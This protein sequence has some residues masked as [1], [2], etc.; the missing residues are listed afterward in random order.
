MAIKISDMNP[1][2]TPALSDEY[3]INQGGVTFRE[4]NQQALDLFNA[5]ALLESTAQVTG[6]DAALAAKLALAGGTMTGDLFLNGD[7][8]VGSQAVNKAYADA[9]G[10]GLTI[11]LECY[12]STTA[13]LAGYTYANGAAGVGATLTAGG[14]GAFT[15]DGTSPSINARIFAPFQSSMFQNGIYALT[16]VGDGSNP[17]VLTRATDYDQTSEI[18]P[19]NLVPVKNGTLY[20]NT[21]WLETAT[22]TTIGTDPINYI[23]F[24]G[25]PDSFL[26]VL[27]NLSDVNNAATSLTNIGGVPTSRTVSAGGLLTGGGDLSANRTITLSTSAVLQPSENLADLDDASDAR[28]NLGLGTA[29]VKDA[30][31][32]A[33]G[34]VVSYDGAP[35]S[36]GVGNLAIYS[37]SN[38]S[39]QDS[40][41]TPHGVASSAYNW[42]QGSNFD[43]NPWLLGTTFTSIANGQYL[44]DR[45]FYTAAAATGLLDCTKT[46]DAPTYAE[47]GIA[48]QN[49][50]RF[51]VS[52]ADASIG[53]TQRYGFCYRML[54]YDWQNLSQNTGRLTFWARSAVTGTY[55]IAFQN[56]GTNR[57]LIQ[58][59]TIN[60]ANTWELKEITLA[61]SP[62][63]GSWNYAN[64]VGLSIIWNL[65][66]GSNFFG[67]DGAWL[68]GANYATSA[69]ANFMAT[70]GNIYG[71]QLVQL[72]IGTE[73]YPFI[74]RPRAT[75]FLLCG[76][77]Q[78]S[79][80]PDGIPP[81]SATGTDG[82]FFVRNQTNTSGFG[83]QLD[84]TQ[85]MINAPTITTYNP[86]AAANSNWRD[87]TNN[88]NRTVAVDVI[89]ARGVALAG[90]AGGSGGNSSSNYI[91]VL[92]E[93]NL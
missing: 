5:E 17:A 36:S 72:T 4:S 24:S 52:T 31:D 88:A 10:A 53:A 20:K 80:F 38:G 34:V 51:T 41:F 1:V 49:S 6:L 14:N 79:T 58:T 48:S 2:V 65:A 67:T 71:I 69:Q 46:A 91:H 61:P 29:A 8:T 64:G 30:S 26:K 22:V 23:Q 15:T 66:T 90:A 7:P 70:V 83:D 39:I 60:L 44:A 78:W 3:E 42:I 28:D 84:F 55:S 74:P 19:G 12:A 18:K 81:D 9:V 50:M 73:V 85:N 21:T 37:D 56:S 89:S 27:N 87:V 54:G 75:E 11:Q 35:G 40:G 59:Y 86:I 25:D 62:T 45:F 33:L 43:D 68:T 47:A 76:Q 92:A 82:A 63:L 57:Y 32:A 93:A 16:T 77:Y 13:N